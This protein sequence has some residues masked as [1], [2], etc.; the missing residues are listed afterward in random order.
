MSMVKKITCVVTA[1]DILGV[2]KLDT[3]PF[4]G[5]Q[6]RKAILNIP[7]LPLTSVIELQGHPI[8]EDGLEPAEAS[9]SWATIATLNSSSEQVQ[10]IELPQYIRYEITTAD[11][12]GPDV[13][14]YLEGV[15]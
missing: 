1:A 9:T 13:L 8:T 2:E 3:S 7:V 6:G 14:L 10:E 12:D 5:G 15:Q 11:V 4:M